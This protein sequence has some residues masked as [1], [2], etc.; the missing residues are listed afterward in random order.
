M[1]LF[2]LERDTY[3][4]VY[5]PQTLTLKP[6]ADI[7]KRDRSKNKTKAVR[8]LS[9]VYFYCDIKSDYMIHID[10]DVRR[11]AIKADL[12]L[13]KNWKID[14]VIATAIEF[15]DSM[16]TS[17]TAEIL[18]DSRY[19]AKTLSNKMKEAVQG[20]D[21]SIDDMSKLMGNITKIP[22]I[23][24]ALQTAEQAVLKEI[25]EAKGSIGSKEKA[26]FEDGL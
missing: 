25:E 16:S 11:D 15:Y 1:K 18:A 2:E 14:K 20:D 26:I 5:E 7:F 8:E 19:T 13:D 10:L 12:V 3:S 22:T 9:F 6:F 24:K 21:L 23:V 17:I 4:V